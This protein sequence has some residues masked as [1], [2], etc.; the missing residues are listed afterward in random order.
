MKNFKFGKKF[1]SSGHKNCALV[2]PIV[3]N[4]KITTTVDSILGQCSLNPLR[5]DELQLVYKRG[6]QLDR[7]RNRSILY[8]LKV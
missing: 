6:H 7:V 4:I 8:C 1:I 2:I 3:T 5:K